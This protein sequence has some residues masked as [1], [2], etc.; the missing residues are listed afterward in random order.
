MMKLVITRYDEID[1]F[2]ESQYF[3]FVN[4]WNF[5]SIAVLLWVAA[6]YPTDWAGNVHGSVSGEESSKTGSC[7]LV[8]IAF[9]S[10]LVESLWHLLQFDVDL[11]W[12]WQFFTVTTEADSGQWLTLIVCLGVT[13][14]ETK[15]F[16]SSSLSRTSLIRL[17]EFSSNLVEYWRLLR[18]DTF[19]KQRRKHR[20]SSGSFSW[21]VSVSPVVL[22]WTETMAV[23]E[24]FFY[25]RKK[26]LSGI[27]NL[28]HFAGR[29]FWWWDEM[30]YFF[31]FKPLLSRKGSQDHDVVTISAPELVSLK[32]WR[33]F[34]R[35]K[36]RE[37]D[38][39]FEK[40]HMLW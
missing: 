22:S 28:L 9:S 21:L 26:N 33:N 8:M 1:F 27:T 11:F 5:A 34:Y 24:L 16:A 19:K 17:A 12:R 4:D 29:N 31:R 39:I 3:L 32:T 40:K 2:G 18:W 38:K 36:T 14:D 13:E 15:W 20:P 30:F 25:F 6:E 35:R 10:H 7:P 23:A 37:S